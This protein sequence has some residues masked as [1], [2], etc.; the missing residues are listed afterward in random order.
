M[1]L[2]GPLNLER[3]ILNIKI[4]FNL[5]EAT[6]TTLTPV[7]VIEDINKI[8]EK[9]QSYNRMWAAMLR[10]HFAPHKMINKDHFTE[11][12]WATMVDL[13]IIK[14]WKGWA[15]PGE[16]VGIIAAQSI[17]E[18]ATQMTLNTFHLAGVAAKSNM[19][20]GVPRLKEM[21]KVTQNPKATSLTIY[22]KPSFRGSKDRVREVAQDLELTLL[23]DITNRVAIYYDPNEE[24]SIIEEDR[25]LLKFYELFEQ[26]ENQTEEEEAPAKWS[27]WLLRLEFDREKMF[28]K[29]ITMDD[30][31]FVLAD[32]FIEQIN[33]VY[34][35]FNSQKLVM[36]IRIA[37]GDSTYGDD[38]IGIKKMQNRLLNNIV[39]RGLPGIR[40]ATFRKDKN[41]KELVAGEYK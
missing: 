17:G 39:I 13:V 12:A 3:V 37:V 35:D 11:E 34:S 16:F 7:R 33:T 40:A 18:P 36:R 20:R 24:S 19:T 31:N 9:T 38:L 26:R 28:N 10:F 8:L 22:M 21:L 14:D 1:E 4:K 5:T 41:R 29:N 6:P 23:K 27:K 2:F 32:K 15:Q 30:V 25:E